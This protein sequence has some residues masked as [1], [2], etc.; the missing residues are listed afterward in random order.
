MLSLEGLETK[1]LYRYL[2]FVIYYA[3]PC[4]WWPPE[5]VWK[6]CR[7]LGDSLAMGQVIGEWLVSPSRCS[8]TSAVAKKDK[9][10]GRQSSSTA[11]VSSLDAKAWHLGLSFIF[12]TANFLKQ[13]RIVTEYFD[14][15]SRNLSYQ[16][17]EVTAKWTNINSENCL[18]WCLPRTWLQL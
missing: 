12:D 6:V 14:L 8:H 11:C 5:Q 16:I 15:T 7:K 1:A 10:L 3:Y 17:L 4:L 18:R 13:L 2:N 9:L